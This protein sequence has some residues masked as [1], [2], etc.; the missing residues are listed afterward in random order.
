MSGLRNTE[1]WRWLPR[2]VFIQ[3]IWAHFLMSFFFLFSIALTELHI[4]VPT[5]TVQEGINS[6]KV[7]WGQKSFCLSQPRP[8]WPAENGVER[9]QRLFECMCLLHPSS[10]SKP[11]FNVNCV[12]ILAG[13]LLPGVQDMFVSSGL[14]KGRKCGFFTGCGHFSSSRWRRA[15]KSRCVIAGLIFTVLSVA[16][17]NFSSLID[18]G[19]WER[20]AARC[21]MGCPCVSYVSPCVERTI[22]S[23]PRLI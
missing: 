11:S 12:F 3:A 9:H 17:A 1:G 19:L 2:R 20:F 15:G 18:F 5:L 22:P 4:S 10:L 7:E 16:S 23:G 6:R 14:I 8:V 13:N 21:T